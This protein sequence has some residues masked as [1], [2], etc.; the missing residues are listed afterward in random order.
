VSK[1]SKADMLEAAELCEAM[2][3]WASGHG[4]DRPIDSDQ[5][6][7]S[8]RKLAQ[9]NNTAATWSSEADALRRGAAMLHPGGGCPCCGCYPDMC[10]CGSELARLTTLRPNSELHED[11]GEVLCWFLS[12]DLKVCEPPCLSSVL[13]DDSPWDDDDEDEMHRW[14]WSPLPDIKGA[15]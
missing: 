3:R 5:W 15:P 13:D 2:Q 9:G 10:E 1:Y 6:S 8:A 12:E 4:G 11:D 14:W 7:I